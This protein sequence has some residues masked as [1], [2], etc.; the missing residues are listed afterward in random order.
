MGIFVVE[1]VFDVPWIDPKRKG[2]IEMCVDL[3]ERRTKTLVVRSWNGNPVENLLLFSV[4]EI[5][6]Y[7]I[8]I[9]YKTGMGV[10]L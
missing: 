5:N 6:L 3:L 7:W 10:L 1:V 9:L 4:V 8:Q 2:I